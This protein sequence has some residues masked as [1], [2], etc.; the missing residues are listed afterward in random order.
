MTAS[1]TSWF[2]PI[3]ARSSIWMARLPKDPPSWTCLVAGPNSRRLRKNA[4]S[5]S[6]PDETLPQSYDI[7]R[8]FRLYKY[9]AEC[10]SSDYWSLLGAWCIIHRIPLP[11]WREFQN[12]HQEKILK[13][14]NADMPRHIRESIP[15]W[16]DE[17]G[18]KEVGEKWAQEL[19]ASN[20]AAKVVIRTNTLKGSRSELKK[21]LAE[22]E[23]ETYSHRLCDDA[24]ILKERQN[25]FSLPLFKEGWFEPQDVGSQLIPPFLKAEAGMRVIDA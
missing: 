14:Y 11:P 13:R 20:E 24:L 7:V 19:A 18:E 15:D 17:L 12:I 6:P 25:I 8:W 10:A 2:A 16:L 5:W 1:M 21:L 22:R 3:T 4:P 9:L 23:I